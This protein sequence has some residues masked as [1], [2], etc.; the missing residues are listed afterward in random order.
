[1]LALGQHRVRAAVTSV[2]VMV[3]GVG[4]EGRGGPAP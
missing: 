3:M 2:K 4:R 1:V